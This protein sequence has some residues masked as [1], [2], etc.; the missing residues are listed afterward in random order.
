MI[1]INLLPVE[2]RK[3]E[4]TPLPRR[5]TIFAGT[6][7]LT[8]L[9]FMLAIQRL[10]TLPDQRAKRTGV[11]ERLDKANERIDREIKPLNAAMASLDR[12]K[13]V[14]AQLQPAVCRWAPRLDAVQDLVTRELEG[15]WIRGFTYVEQPSKSKDRKAAGTLDRILTVTFAASDFSER[16][17]VFTMTNEAR[18]ADVVNRFARKAVFNRDLVG[19]ATSAWET[20]ADFNKSP[21]NVKA[22]QFQVRFQFKPVAPAEPDRKPAPPRPAE[23]A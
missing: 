8:G 13:R 3:R 16:Q 14:M 2:M 20:S 6:A 17:S 15:V 5:I 10:Q 18:I 9:G 4:G 23:K 1:R 7:V 19:V 21:W 22:I 12:R 11:A